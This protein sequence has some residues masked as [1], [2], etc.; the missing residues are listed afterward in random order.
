MGKWSR[1]VSIIGAAY[2]PFGNV[3]ETPAIKGM[4][5]RELISWAALEAMEKLKAGLVK[6]MESHQASR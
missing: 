2:T 1:G 6:F 5:Y 3:L 4:T